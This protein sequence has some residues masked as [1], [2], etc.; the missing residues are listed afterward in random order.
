M[1]NAAFEGYD[2]WDLL[3]SMSR[4]VVLSFAETDWC[5]DPLGRKPDQLHCPSC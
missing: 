4:Y 3:L 1:G 5:G 2:E